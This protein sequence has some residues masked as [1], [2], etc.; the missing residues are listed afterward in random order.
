MTSDSNQNRTSVWSCPFSKDLD[1][2][3]ILSDG[4]TDQWIHHKLSQKC[5][6]LFTTKYQ[7]RSQAM[8]ESDPVTVPSGPPENVKNVISFFDCYEKYCQKNN[9]NIARVTKT[10]VFFPASVVE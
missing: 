4:K 10:N 2:D 5:Y 1:I 7:K 9:G 3:N 6:R 8:H